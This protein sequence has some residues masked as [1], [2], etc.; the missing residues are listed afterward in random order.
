MSVSNLS[1]GMRPGV[2]LSTSRPTVP[3]E[4]QMIYE[5]DTDMVA[6][7]NGT[8]WRYVSATTP[9]NGTVL[10][11]VI[12]TYS[13]Q[14]GKSN[15]TFGS[16]GLTA[17]ITPKSTSSKIL[18]MFTQTSSTSGGGVTLGLRLVQTIGGSDTVLQTWSYALMSASNVIYSNFSQN[19]LASPA[20]TS[21]VTFRTDMNS[22]TG[23]G[24]VYTQVGNTPSNITL[25]EI[26]G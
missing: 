13:T 17:T 23:S 6:I 26:A 12:G 11:V 19:V 3:Y 7:W 21:A 15:G 4:G 5:T 18:V 1:T 20:T 24:D 14:T 9:T 10:Q 16:T 25:M 22:S 2:C 8:S